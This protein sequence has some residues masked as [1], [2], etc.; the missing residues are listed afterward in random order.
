MKEHP[1]N[2]GK[3]N[4]RYVGVLID[5]RPTME[6]RFLLVLAT[7]NGEEAEYPYPHLIRIL[8]GDI[9]KRFASINLTWNH[10]DIEKA[11]EF[12]KQIG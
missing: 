10:T 9:V 1:I 3:V 8:P 4:N 7:L 6:D 12:A 5:Q 11:V 2:F